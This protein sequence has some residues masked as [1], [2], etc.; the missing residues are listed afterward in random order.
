MVVTVMSPM[1]FTEQAVMQLRA[2]GSNHPAEA[3]YLF[4]DADAQ[5]RPPGKYNAATSYQRRRTSCSAGS[6]RFVE[7]RPRACRRISS[8]RSSSSRVGYCGG[9][10]SVRSMTRD[11]RLWHRQCQEL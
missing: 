8:G 2:I 7:Y 1:S 11:A 3:I 9:P 10:W 5:G 6:S 4:A